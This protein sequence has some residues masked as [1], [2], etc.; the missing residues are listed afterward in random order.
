MYLICRSQSINVSAMPKQLKRKEME[1]EIVLFCFSGPQ[2]IPETCNRMLGP[3]RFISTA[4]WMRPSGSPSP[5]ASPTPSRRIP[6]RQI[7]LFGAWSP[8]AIF[9]KII[10]LPVGQMRALFTT[11][12][13][14]L[15]VSSYPLHPRAIE[16]GWG[17]RDDEPAFRLRTWIHV[18]KLG[19]PIRMQWNYVVCDWAGPWPWLVEALLIAGVILI[20]DV[21]SWGPAASWLGLRKVDVD[22]DV[23]Q[24]GTSVIVRAGKWQL[25]FSLGS[26]YL[27]V[28]KLQIIN[29]TS[30]SN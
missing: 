26:V 9:Y 19:Q 22:I 23:C 8:P 7:K 27:P 13:I 2:C 14:A 12:C 30:V 16:N 15:Q 25:G 5:S 20:I 3:R 29:T 24:P 1:I 17:V 6:S 18:G 11:T 10:A 28:K 21:V 4:R